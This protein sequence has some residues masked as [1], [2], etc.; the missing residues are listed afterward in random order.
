M[1]PICCARD[2]QCPEPF[3]TC[4]AFKIRL[5]QFLDREGYPS[6]AAPPPNFEGA[7][8]RNTESGRDVAPTPQERCTALD[9]CFYNPTLDVCIM[10]P[11]GNECDERDA[12]GAV[13]ATAFDGVCSEV[14]CLDL[15]RLAELW[16]K[17]AH[18]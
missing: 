17:Y 12:N 5:G 11:P 8:F 16:G 13:V 18:S 4:E 15:V 2:G 14:C 7:Y 1:N 3:G 10:M 6:G 9:G